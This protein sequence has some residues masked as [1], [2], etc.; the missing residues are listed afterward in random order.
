[1]FSLC[2]TEKVLSANNLEVEDTSF[3]RSVIYIRKNGGLRIDP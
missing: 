1:M 3:N 2:A